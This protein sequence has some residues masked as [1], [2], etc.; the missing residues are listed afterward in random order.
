MFDIAA[1]TVR[2]LIWQNSRHLMKTTGQH[3]KK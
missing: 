2:H 3:E 1:Y